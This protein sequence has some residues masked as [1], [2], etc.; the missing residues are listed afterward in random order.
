MRL[1]ELNQRFR[2]QLAQHPLVQGKALVTGEGL[3]YRPRLMLVGEAPGEQ[4]ALQGR[5]FVG[6]AGKMLDTF[7]EI[8]CI[9]RSSIYI[10]NTVK[11][12]PTLQG[13]YGRLSNRPPTPDE[14]ALFLP[15]LMEETAVVNPK[16][17][18]TLGNTPLKAFLGEQ[19]VVGRYH[20]RN[21]LT[22]QG[23][24]L[25]ALYHPAAVIYNPS[26]SSAYE[27]DLIL[28]KGHL[29]AHCSV[30]AE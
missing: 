9:A 28:L 3:C 10:T 21:A 18:V 30:V 25:Y 12:R 8:L 20:G 4:E 7:L 26:L 1:E 27:Q 19:A 23:V 24:P 5:P 11:I 16:L 14:L 17:L 13:P 29:A 2:E 6:K 22:T 15:W